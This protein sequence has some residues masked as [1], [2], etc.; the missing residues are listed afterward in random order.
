MKPTIR[1]GF[2]I[3]HLAAF[4]QPSVAQ[5]HLQLALEDFAGHAQGVIT[6]KTV[7]SFPIV[8]E[9]QLEYFTADIDGN[10]MYEIFVSRPDLSSG[11]IWALYSDRIDA[12]G[13]II[14]V[15]II[16]LRTSG[17][18]MGERDGVKGFYEYYHGGAGQG[19]LLFNSF[20]KNGNLIA[21]SE[22]TVELQGKDK[23]IMDSLHFGRF[24]PEAKKPDIKILPLRPVWES[25]IKR[26]QSKL[27]EGA[28]NQA[29]GTRNPASGSFQKKIGKVDQLSDLGKP[30]SYS[31]VW[32]LIIGMLAMVVGIAYR[33]RDRFQRWLTDYCPPLR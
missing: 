19:T 1:L 7:D 16:E 6:G 5:T 27:R 30:P 10:G 3:L 24:D 23:A 20:D 26:T 28:Q 29:G 18:R 8:S 22:A 15:G 4:V 17:M 2:L 13:N 31:W 32:W 25:H 21:L 9:A 14:K 33:H 12:N 11:D